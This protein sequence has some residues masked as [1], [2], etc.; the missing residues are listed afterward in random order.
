MNRAQPQLMGSS[1][2]TDGLKANEV[3]RENIPATCEGAW[4]L[5]A[6]CKLYEA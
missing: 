3:K 6:N 2:P 5:A 1:I 4:C